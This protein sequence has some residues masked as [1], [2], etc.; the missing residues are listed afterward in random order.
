MADY[1]IQIGKV[2]FAG[3]L[4]II[5]TID[6]IVG[7]Q[8]F[9]YWQLDQVETTEDFNQPAKLKSLLSAQQTRL[10]DYRTVDAKKGIVAIPISRAMQ[11]VVAELSQKGEPQ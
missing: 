5:L 10:T 8:A 7:L 6:L 9:Y 1:G 2:F 11:L 4:G 3:L